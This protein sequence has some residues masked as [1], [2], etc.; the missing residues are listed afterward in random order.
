MHH[1][2]E[3]RLVG[4]EATD[5]DQLFD[6]GAFFHHADGMFVRLVGGIVDID[7][8]LAFGQTPPAY[9]RAASIM[10]LTLLFI[11]AFMWLNV[12]KGKLAEGVDERDRKSVV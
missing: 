8:F 11:G 3:F 4:A 2:Q 1:V 6:T 5:L 9:G 10:M 7:L 12:K